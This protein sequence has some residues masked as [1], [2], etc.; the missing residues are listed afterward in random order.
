MF[1]K[2][3]DYFSFKIMKGNTGLSWSPWRVPAMTAV[4]WQPHLSPD[5]LPSSVLLTESLLF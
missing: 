2:E 3:E 4:Q 1:W 5:D